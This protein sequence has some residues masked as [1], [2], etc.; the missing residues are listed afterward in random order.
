LYWKIIEIPN[1]FN[2]ILVLPGQGSFTRPFAHNAINSAL[3]KAL[4]GQ[5]ISAFTIHGLRHCLKFGS[6]NRASSASFQV[7]YFKG[8]CNIIVEHKWAQAKAIRKQYRCSV[9]ELF[10]KHFKL[11]KL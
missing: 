1:K 4:Q 6:K 10:A 11:G 8:A 2:N 3:K 7:V 9:D 5:K